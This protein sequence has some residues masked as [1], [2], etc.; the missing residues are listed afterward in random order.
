[1]FLFKRKTFKPHEHMWGEVQPDGRQ[2]CLTCNEAH[3][4]AI[5]CHHKFSIINK[6]AIK[7]DDV[8]KE[9]IYVSQCIHCGKIVK[10]KI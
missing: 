8:I 6:H 4:V 10:E 1:M 9:I 5:N 2:Y 7:Y 3:Y